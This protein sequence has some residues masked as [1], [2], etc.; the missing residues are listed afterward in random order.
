MWPNDRTRKEDPVQ[1]SGTISGS[2]GSQGS[3]GWLLF[4]LDKTDGDKNIRA[5]SAIVLCSRLS[6]KCKADS[7]YQGA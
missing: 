5:T 4:L 7:A 6:P 2:D 1:I 3:S